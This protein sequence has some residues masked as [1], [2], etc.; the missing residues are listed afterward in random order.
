MVIEFSARHFH[1]ADSVREYAKK[2]VEKFKKYNERATH[3]QIILEHEHNEH[4][5]E[6]KLSV[7][8][9]NFFAKAVSSKLTKSIDLAVE[10]TMHQLKKHKDISQNHKSD[11]L[12]VDED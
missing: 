4:T 5:V 12:N 1:A 9:N 6:I 8:G 10:K 7:P 3:C 11:G 2:E